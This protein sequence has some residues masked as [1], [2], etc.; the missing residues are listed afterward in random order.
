[1]QEEGED[2]EVCTEKPGIAVYR[3]AVRV[4]SMKLVQLFNLRIAKSVP[5]QVLK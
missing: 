1:M 3:E 4:S 5:F 2:S